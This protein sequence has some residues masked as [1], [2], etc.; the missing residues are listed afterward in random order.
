MTPVGKIK[1]RLPYLIE[2]ESER[3]CFCLSIERLK[4]SLA[5]ARRAQFGQTSEL[6][7]EITNQ[8]ELAIRSRREAG[9]DGDAGGGCHSVDY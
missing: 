6:G 7:K 2:V 1:S 8:L 3:T 5:K 4:L 9:R